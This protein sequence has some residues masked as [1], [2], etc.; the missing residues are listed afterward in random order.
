MLLSFID[1]E[2]EE[3]EFELLISHP[4]GEQH[5]IDAHHFRSFDQFG[6]PVIMAIRSRPFSSAGGKR[7][8]IRRRFNSQQPFQQMNQ[9]AIRIPISN[10]PGGPTVFGPPVML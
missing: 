4:R 6:R 9:R 3:E 2:D 1:T 10:V 8:K 5:V 7:K